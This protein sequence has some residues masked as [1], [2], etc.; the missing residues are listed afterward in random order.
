M[1][2][3]EYLH[4]DKSG[5]LRKFL[6][7]LAISVASVTVVS[8]VALA[9]GTLVVSP[10]TNLTNGQT[11]TVSGSGFAH[12]STGAI[13][14]CNSD[15]GQPT[16]VVAG[17]PVPVSCTNP[18]SAITTTD[19]SG[20]LAAKTFTVHTG[21]VGPPTTGTDSSGGSATTDAAKYPCPP[22][23]AQIA[24]G[25]ACVITFGD[26]ANDDVSQNISFTAPSQPNP[27]TPTPTPTTPTTP[28]ATPTI[29][30]KTGTTTTSTTLPNTGSG[31]TIG[32]FIGTVMLGG[33]IRYAYFVHRR[34]KITHIIE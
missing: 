3:Q 11:V 10:S 12:N 6:L 28:P 30:A 16:V 29:P 18:L 20:N 33:L 21:T 24:A 9:A 19:K 17:N 15:T 23:A 13:L 2:S 31:N 8:S 34:D 32:L 5:K 25:D 7:V 27:P 4:L 22:T 26:A 1:P 14:E